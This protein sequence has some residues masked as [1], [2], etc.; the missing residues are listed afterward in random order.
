MHQMIEEIL[1][2]L[3]N[4]CA[5]FGEARRRGADSELLPPLA[6]REWRPGESCTVATG[7][8]GGEAVFFQ[9]TKASACQWLCREGAKGR[10]VQMS[11][12]Y[13]P[14]TFYCT[15]Y[16][17]SLP[18]GELWFRGFTEVIS[19]DH[20]AGWNWVKRGTGK[21][22]AYILH[23]EE[24]SVLYFLYKTFQLSNKKADS[25]N[26]HFRELES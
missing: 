11:H 23:N 9:R 18:S 1:M 22:K 24:G 2:I 21:V 16:W 25:P 20:R 17:L 3:A 10:N 15:S 14:L 7:V 4:M 12:S 19:L 26:T 13:W 8:G 5:E 6:W